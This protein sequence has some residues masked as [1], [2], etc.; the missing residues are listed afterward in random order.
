[1]DVSIGAIVLVIGAAVLLFIGLGIPSR[2]ANLPQ[3]VAPRDERP[4]PT[5]RG[6]D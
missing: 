6:R 2:R 4:S 1:M 5:G 3:R